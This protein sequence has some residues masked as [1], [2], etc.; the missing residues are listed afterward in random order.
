MALLTVPHVAVRGM[1]A[2]VPPQTEATR[3]IEF[4]STPEEAA[5]VEA[6][7]GVVRKHVVKDSGVTG[8]DLCIL[9]AERLLDSLGWE[10]DSIDLIVNITQTSDYINHPNVFVAHERL[11]LKSGCMSLD[12]FHGCPGWVI[13]MMSATSLI[14]HGTIRRCL[15]LDG[16]NISSMQWALDRES[17]PLF[18][19]CGTATALEFDENASPIHFE[20]GTDSSDGKA[21]IHP[22]GG[23][24]NPFS[25]DS[26]KVELDLRSGRLQPAVNGMDGMSVFSFGISAPPRSI[27]RLCEAFGIELSCI[28]K[29]VLHQANLFMVQ[30]I[31]K[32]L[33]VDSK[34]VP[35]SL[36]EYGNV[37][38][39]SIPLTIVSQCAEEYRNKPV[40]TVACGFGTG[41]SW[42]SMYMETDNLIIPDI[43]IYGA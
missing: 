6:T 22:D 30:K 14:S 12:L 16:D 41:L 35:V 19:D 38:S 29:L 32:K 40:K 15:M 33:K 26:L 5:N 23:Y 43:I 10:R 36:E 34:R 20:T 13:G 9:A 11:G 37:T 17:R 24:R 1:A 21:L 42:A 31:A 39:A 3:D 25:L 8:A 18:G 2:C 27:K 28:D 4:Y 7:T